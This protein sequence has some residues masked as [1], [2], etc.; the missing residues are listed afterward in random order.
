MIFPEWINK[1]TRA[2][3]NIG[4]KRSNKPEEKEAN[5]VKVEKDGRVREMREMDLNSWAETAAVAADIA[6]WKQQMNSLIL[7]Q[8]EDGK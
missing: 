8:S 7:H 4:A 6:A 3:H 5:H 1:K 2:L